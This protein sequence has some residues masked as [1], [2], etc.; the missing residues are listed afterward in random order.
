M[1]EMGLVRCKTHEAAGANV[2]GHEIRDC[3]GC[4]RAT[5]DF[6]QE[7]VESLSK[8]VET[9]TS[10]LFDEHVDPFIAKM[11]SRGVTLV[12]DPAVRYHLALLVKKLMKE[13]TDGK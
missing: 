9:P 12:S 2:E 7:E 10:K 13:K 11:S 1:D 5:R 4:V 3:I 6:L 8:M